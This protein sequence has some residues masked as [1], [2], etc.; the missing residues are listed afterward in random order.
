MSDISPIHDHSGSLSSVRVAA[1][2][3][4]TRSF[5]SRDWT[6]LRS[7]ILR[8]EE[9]SWNGTGDAAASAS[10]FRQGTRSAE[11]VS[12]ADEAGDTSGER[13]DLSQDSAITD[14]LS[15][16]ARHLEARIRTTH[17][18][19]ADALADSDQRSL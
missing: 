8:L 1:W 5:F 17:K 12:A 19:E 3:A 6:R 2:A 7:L 11:P 16:L 10:A 15:E 18:S 4:E 9:E 14:R 13:A